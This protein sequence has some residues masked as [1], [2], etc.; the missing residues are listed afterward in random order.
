[1]IVTEFMSHGALDSFLRVSGLGLGGRLMTR[2][3]L[4]P[5]LSLWWDLGLASFLIKIPTGQPDSVGHRA[6]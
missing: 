4:L 1:M 5:H 6:H 3:F 2:R